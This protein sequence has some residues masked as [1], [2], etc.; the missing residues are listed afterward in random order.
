M[1]AIQIC[2]LQ[3]SPKL[4][5]LFGS[6]QKVWGLKGW[7]YPW[8]HQFSRCACIYC[9]FWTFGCFN[10]N[11]SYGYIKYTSNSLEENTW[12]CENPETMHV[13]YLG[14][15]SCG[16]LWV[17]RDQCVACTPCGR[18]PVSR[19]ENTHGEH[20][21]ETRCSGQAED[22]ITCARQGK[23]WL[24]RVVLSHHHGVPVAMEDSGARGATGH[25]HRIKPLDTCLACISASEVS[26][27]SIKGGPGH[28]TWPPHKATWHLSS[29]HLG[30][31]SIPL[32]YKRRTRP[33]S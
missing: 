6:L 19:H 2:Y 26:P 23:D 17:I 21:S 25:G 5:L 22:I 16:T 20:A 28:P 15:P 18:R 10:S 14:A 32:K 11:L 33:R 31:W 7:P 9:I 30:Q 29:M 8:F 3:S 27:W 24:D 1:H 13:S 4:L 12:R